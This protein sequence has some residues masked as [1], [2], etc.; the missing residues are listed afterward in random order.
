MATAQKTVTA[1][2]GATR[3]PAAV[4]PPEPARR[5][6]FNVEEYYKMAEVGILKRDERV[7]LIDGDI[8]VMCPIGSP[9]AVCVD[10]L[11]E[12][13]VVT[14]LNRA[15]IRVQGPLRLNDL[16][17]PEPDLQVLKP[18]PKRYA[19]GHPGPADVFF[20]IEVMVSSADS[21]RRDKLGR[22]ARAG[23]PEV[24]LVDLNRDLVEVY[25]RPTAEGYS[26]TQE[27]PRGQGLAPE[28]FPEVVLGVDAILG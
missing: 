16:S 17:E 1:E 9:H 22:F 10:G 11:T 26:E 28:A 15:I 19:S 27:F 14:F 3:P 24:W 5:R 8:L 21:D 6:Q 25:R 4:G 23:V 7:E 2:Q 20:L 18:G 12:L 13:L